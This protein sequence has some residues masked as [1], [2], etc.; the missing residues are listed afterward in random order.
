MWYLQQGAEAIYIARDSTSI[1]DLALLDKH[2]PDFAVRKLFIERNNSD[3]VNFDTLTHF[4]CHHG[5][6][7]DVPEPSF[8]Y[9][10]CTLDYPAII[11]PLVTRH[12]AVNETLVCDRRAPMAT[13][14]K[15]TYV[16]LDLQGSLFFK[17]AFWAL[18]LS[19]TMATG[20]WESVVQ[21]VLWRQGA[22]VG[23]WSGKDTLTATPRPSTA[24]NVDPD[25]IYKL[26]AVQCLSDAEWSASLCVNKVLV[27]LNSYG[28]LQAQDTVLLRKWFLRV[29]KSVPYDLTGEVAQTQCLP[30]MVKYQPINAKHREDA[31]SVKTRIQLGKKMCTPHLEKESLNNIF[32]L[33]NNNNRKFDDMLL[34]VVFNNAFYSTIPY[35]E[36]LIR[37]FWPNILY[38]GPDTM[39]SSARVS[40]VSFG[41]NLPGYRRGSFNYRCVVH[42]YSMY[43]YMPGGYFITNDDILLLPHLI[44]PLPLDSVWFVQHRVVMDF[45]RK[46]PFRDGKCDTKMYYSWI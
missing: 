7:G 41:A 4:G 31:T 34:I 30:S 3:E 14:H 42:A 19:V 21:W 18:P 40:Y 17:E 26:S 33:I 44:S 16:D 22:H 20:L 15:G 12:T 27:S 28:I 6:K 9:T 32:N 35:I 10:L 46:C 37:A 25:F 11:T 38:C 43:P 39:T 5:N 8:T 13:A 36:L 29:T 1:Q 2:I 45:D 24:A 23:V